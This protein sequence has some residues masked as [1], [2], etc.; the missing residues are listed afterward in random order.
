L[1]TPDTILRR[2]LLLLGVV[3]GLGLASIFNDFTIAFA[4]LDDVLGVS[5]AYAW[6]KAAMALSPVGRVEE[7]VSMPGQAGSGIIQPSRA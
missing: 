1:S 4:L 6:Y 2:H 3:S 5:V 7:E